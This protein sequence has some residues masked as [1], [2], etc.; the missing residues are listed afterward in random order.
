M[1]TKTKNV[2]LVIDMHSHFFPERW[3]D[4]EIKFGSPDWPWI[5]HHG[6]G[7]ATVMIGDKVFRPIYSACWDTLKRIEEMDEHGV[8][9][10]II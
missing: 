4:F 1:T 2:P 7:K 6:D 8:D 3:P 9:K 10:Q 5:K